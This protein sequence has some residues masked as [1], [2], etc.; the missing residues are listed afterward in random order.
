VGT[1]LGPLVTR[2]ITGDNPMMMLWAILFTYTFMVVGYFT[3]GWAY[4]LPI[5]LL[6]T[7]IRTIGTGVNWVYSSSLLQMIV[8]GNFLG[9]VF[10]FDLAMMTLAS[11]TSTLWIGWAKDNLELGARE[12]AMSLGVVP[13]VMAVLWLIYITWQ[14]KKR[15]QASCAAEVS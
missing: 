8:P 9:R 1:G 7:F 14:L 3:I 2:R 15:Q 10:A 13:L 6:G 4:F 12:L 5:L 11:S